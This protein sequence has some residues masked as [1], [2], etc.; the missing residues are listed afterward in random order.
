MSEISCGN[1]TEKTITHEKGDFLKR[2]ISIWIK[3][4]AHRKEIAD[5]ILKGESVYMDIK[6]FNDPKE[7]KKKDGTPVTDRQGNQLFNV[8]MLTQWKSQPF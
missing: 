2:S 3:D 1:V 6:M 4:E 7:M 8:G 5:K